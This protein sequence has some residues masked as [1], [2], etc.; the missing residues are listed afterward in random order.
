MKQANT[1]EPQSLFLWRLPEEPPITASY[2]LEIFSLDPSTSRRGIRRRY[3]ICHQRE[4][5]VPFASLQHPATAEPFI[6]EALF[7]DAN[8]GRGP[9]RDSCTAANNL[10]NHLVGTSEQ[11]RCEGK[12]EC[13]CGFQVDDQLELGGEGNRQVGGLAALVSR[14]SASNE[15]AWAAAL[16]KIDSLAAQEGSQGFTRQELAC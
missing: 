4:A 11:R 1:G 2:P 13:L 8:W 7:A 6:A 15:I 14:C 10:F 5:L 12:A 3:R 16:R 9:Q